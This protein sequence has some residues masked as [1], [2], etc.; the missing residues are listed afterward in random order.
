MLISVSIAVTLLNISHSLKANEPITF[1]SQPNIPTLYL[2]KTYAPLLRELSD[3]I[4]STI[5]FRTRRSV[6]QYQEA[7]E[8][9]EFDI[10]IVNAFAYVAVRENP[11]FHGLVRRA[12]QQHAE[13]FVVDPTL[14][15]LDDLKGKRIGFPPLEMASSIIGLHKLHE[16][17][18]MAND[19]QRLLFNE[20]LS[21]KQGLSSGHVDAC[22]SSPL[23]IEDRLQQF[24]RR[25][26]PIAKT[27]SIPSSVIMIH[28]R[29]LHLET[30][31]RNWFLNLNN[32]EQGRNYLRN[33]YLGELSEIN[34]SDY[35]EVAAI[36]Q[37]RSQ[38]GW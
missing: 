23:F 34:D 31:L 5:H 14:K 2:E 36:L 8:N 21:C 37:N 35:D 26:I 6:T 3:R 18:F 29:I 27:R 24:N 15:S 25:F 20:H 16:A 7:I 11:K 12:V 10:F 30:Q 22:V 13:F 1:A 9:E 38:Q 19:Y 33:T 32:T 17:G 4:D 28:E